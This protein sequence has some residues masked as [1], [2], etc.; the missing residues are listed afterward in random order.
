MFTTETRRHGGLT[1]NS[2]SGEVI[3]AAIEVHRE[4]GPGLLESVYE[5]CLCAELGRRGIPY[6]RQVALPI[7]YK[8]KVLEQSFRIDLLVGD[9]VLVEVKSLEKALPVH[10]AQLLTYLQLSDKKIGLLLNFNV[11][12]LKDGIIRRV[13]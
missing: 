3:G 7:H 13:L 8:G 9:E 6:A 11:P 12:V 2:I 4:L 10:T 1:E 5:A